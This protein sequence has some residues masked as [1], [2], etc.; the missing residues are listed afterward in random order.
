M[1]N[2]FVKLVV[3]Y[4]THAISILTKLQ[5]HLSFRNCKYRLTNNQI[6]TENNVLMVK[7]LHNQLIFDNCL[8]HV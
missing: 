8:G 6:N 3:N 2:L 7:A 4:N 1:L 5:I